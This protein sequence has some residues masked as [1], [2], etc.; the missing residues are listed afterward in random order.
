MN[1]TILTQ[2]GIS[3][4]GIGGGIW[5]TRHTGLWLVV[6]GAAVFLAGYFLERKAHNQKK[7]DEVEE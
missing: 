3:A 7:Q 2:L 6:L 1:P 5:F 4:L